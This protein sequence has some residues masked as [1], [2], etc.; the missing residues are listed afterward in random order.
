MSVGTNHSDRISQAM[1]NALEATEWGMKNFGSITTNRRLPLKVMRQCVEAG[2]CQC[3]GSVSL[4]D[5]DGFTIQPE[6]QRL[7]YVLT[8]SG[9]KALGELRKALRERG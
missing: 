2:L 9:R 7:G 1:F 8:E 6:R 3:I 5:D 4:C